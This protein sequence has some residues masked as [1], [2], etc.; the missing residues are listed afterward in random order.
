MTKL[1]LVFSEPTVSST[2][3]SNVH[4]ESKIEPQNRRQKLIPG[5]L[6]DLHVK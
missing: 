3:I 1:V 5:N 2:I 4:G 6:K